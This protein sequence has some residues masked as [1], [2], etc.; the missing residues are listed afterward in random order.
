MT[1]QGQV[2]VERTLALDGFGCFE[3]SFTLPE[4]AGAG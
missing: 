3:G 1:A 4:P 2:L